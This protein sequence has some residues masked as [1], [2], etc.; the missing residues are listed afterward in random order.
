[1]L[2]SLPFDPGLAPAQVYL[3]DLVGSLATVSGLEIQS[4]P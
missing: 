3:A 1:L 4:L 2:K